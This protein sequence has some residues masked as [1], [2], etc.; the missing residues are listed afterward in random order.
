MDFVKGLV[1]QGLRMAYDELD[2][3]FKFPDTQDTFVKDMVI[4]A[5]V[6]KGVPLLIGLIQSKLNSKEVPVTENK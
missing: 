5:L 1:V 3:Q 4:P 6:D 2:K